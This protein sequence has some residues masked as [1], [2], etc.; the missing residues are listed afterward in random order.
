MFTARYGLSPYITQIRLFLK[1][2]KL[3]LST[4]ALPF[5][6]KAITIFTSEPKTSKNSRD[7]RLTPLSKRDPTLLW[8]VTQRR[9]IFTDVSGQPIDPI[10]MGHKS[11]VCK[12]TEER[13]SDGT[14]LLRY[15]SWFRD[16]VPN[17]TIS[18]VSTAQTEPKLQCRC[19]E[20]FKE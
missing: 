1:G 20:V 9:L 3:F 8:N 17:I 14:N 13:R 2:L 19:R 5:E 10:F 7:F 4:C 6:T 12:I 11:T 16:R 15:K 18:D